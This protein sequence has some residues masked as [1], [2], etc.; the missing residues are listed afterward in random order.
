M[1]KA[2]HWR[3]GVVEGG[4]KRDLKTGKLLGGRETF[5]VN[6]IKDWLGEKG[7]G[8]LM[9]FS[10][11]ARE[12][13]SVAGELGLSV[14]KFA[15]WGMIAEVILK[16]LGGMFKGA[17]QNAQSLVRA[18]ADLGSFIPA[19]SKG[20]DMFTNTRTAA[21][22]YG[23]KQEEILEAQNKM[24][25]G[26]MF[27]S[28]MMKKY[29]EEGL[30]GS[31]T[32]FMVLAKAAGISGAAAGELAENL[33]LTG[34]K[35]DSLSD[36]FLEMNYQAISAGMN[37]S[38]MSKIL[39]VLAPVSITVANSSK[40]LYT[41]IGMFNQAWSNSTDSVIKFLDA[42]P[43]RKAKAFGD[44]M[45]QFGQV[46]AKLADDIPMLLAF[47]GGKTDPG[48]DPFGALG[49]ALGKQPTDIAMN[50]IKKIM[51]QGGNEK[52]GLMGVVT[53]MKQQGATTRGAYTIAAMMQE[54]LSAQQAVAAGDKD[55]KKREQEANLKLITAA[56][57][58]LGDPMERLV[59]L[60]QA[61]LGYIK[62]ALVAS[63]PGQWFASPVAG[64]PQSADGT[65]KR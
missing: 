21:I 51:E 47:S 44:A 55:A 43:E 32:D 65:P 7:M 59:E 53:M 63:H 33:M 30:T 16:A 8:Q 17:A 40:A 4:L 50:Y 45:S 31:L 62:I 42:N 1:L 10:K 60:L 28:A 9:G 13:S 6:P 52:T 12:A 35:A 37:I 26:L 15:V 57:Q 41:Q 58:E 39:G 19:M 5:E 23:I 38:Y 36:G 54:L 22:L 25:D 34:T 27:N 20:L 61:I 29:T 48:K 2:R 64:V 14:G 49:E 18:G 3:M 46:S 11:G 24:A 56:N